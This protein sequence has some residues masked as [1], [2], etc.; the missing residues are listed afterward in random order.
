MFL[1]VVGWFIAGI[2]YVDRVQLIRIEIRK[3]LTLR[4]HFPSEAWNARGLPAKG[5][6]AVCKLIAPCYG[7]PNHFFLPDDRNDLLFLDQDGIGPVE[8]LSKIENELGINLRGRH[9]PCNGV[10]ADFVHKIAPSGLA[11]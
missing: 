11:A 2:L 7:M 5:A 3:Q 10:L 8:V 4:K 9:V 1:P 6:E